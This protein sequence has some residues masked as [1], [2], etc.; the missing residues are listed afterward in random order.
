MI[1]SIFSTRPC[2]SALFL[3]FSTP[4]HPFQLVLEK[5]SHVGVL[6]RGLHIFQRTQPRHRA[7][8]RITRV[9]FRGHALGV[10]P[11]REGAGLGGGDVCAWVIAVTTVG[12][13]LVGHPSEIARHVGL[14]REGRHAL[15]FDVV[16][17][18]ACAVVA[19]RGVNAVGEVNLD[20]RIPFF[21]HRVDNA[22]V[23]F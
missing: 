13:I 7:L 9:K 21:S 11:A 14:W 18:H 20:R 12:A 19:V 3:Y 10:L 1:L 6:R 8:L 16:V 23:A 15:D 2:Y 17:V 5:Q 4:I 22:D